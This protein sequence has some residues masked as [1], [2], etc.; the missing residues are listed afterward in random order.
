MTKHNRYTNYFLN[1]YFYL[2]DQILAQS[3]LSFS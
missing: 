2:L 3:V 1:I